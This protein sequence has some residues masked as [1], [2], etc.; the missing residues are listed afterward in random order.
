[1]TNNRTLLQGETPTTPFRP[2][3]TSKQR[4]L[5]IG[6]IA[7]YLAASFLL[8]PRPIPSERYFMMEPPGGYTL[9]L[10]QNGRFTKTSQSPIH[11]YYSYDL[12]Q[13]GT[14]KSVG[15]DLI[16]LKLDAGSRRDRG[17]REPV[18]FKLN[19]EEKTFFWHRPE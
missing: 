9:T 10:M 3:L 13:T 8:A 4:Q 15:E 2:P 12:N 1:M 11:I 19:R 14:W 5:F 6:L 16:S 18:T 7:T 17:F